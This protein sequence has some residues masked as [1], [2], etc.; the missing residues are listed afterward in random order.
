VTPKEIPSEEAIK[1]RKPKE[2][3][4]VSQLIIFHLVQLCALL[5]LSGYGRNLVNQINRGGLHLAMP[6]IFALL[7]HISYRAGVAM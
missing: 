6:T 5:Y 3:P 7:V 1:T 2:T 4:G